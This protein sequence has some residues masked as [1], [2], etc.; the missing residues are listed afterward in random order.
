MRIAGNLRG[1]RSLPTEMMAGGSV[2]ELQAAVREGLPDPRVATW[3][4]WSANA[5]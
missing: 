2:A 4:T 3:A 5:P 1:G